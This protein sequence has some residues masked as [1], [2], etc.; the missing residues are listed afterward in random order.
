MQCAEGLL[1][2]GNK[3]AAKATYEKLLGNSPSEVVKV[4]A[5]RGLQ[6]C[7]AN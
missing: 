6:M 4:A 5:T 3:D 7:A 2:G 1:A